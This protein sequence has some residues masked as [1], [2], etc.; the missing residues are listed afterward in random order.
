MLRRCVAAL[1]IAAAPGVATAQQGP[2][3]D[4][5]RRVKALEA[6]VATLK[7]ELSAVDRRQVR[8]VC[9]IEVVGDRVQD[10]S[11]PAGF[12]PSDCETYLQKTYG[13]A[14]GMRVWLGC[15]S[16]GAIEF[17]PIG[18]QPRPNSCGW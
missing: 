8:K 9:R 1:V 12:T 2:I 3:G 17:W 4:L 11:V 10:V 13:G 15:L 5:D 18:S 7:R 16:R 14:Q 6:E